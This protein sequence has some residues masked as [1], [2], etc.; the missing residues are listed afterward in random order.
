[1][2]SKLLGGAAALALTA[3]TVVAS[4]VPASAQHWRHWHHGWHNGW[5][6]PAAAA[7]GIVGGAV[8]AATSPLWAPGYYDYYP[9]YAY[10]GY[11]Y[12]DYAYNP[13]YAQYSYNDNGGYRN[14]YD[15]YDN[16]NNPFKN[17]GQ[18]NYTYG[19]APGTATVVAQNGDNV[20][21][22]QSRYRSYDPA[23]GTFLGFDGKRH[24]CP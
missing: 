1:M 15:S 9:N 4:S 16:S 20:A 24:P 12:P 2:K 6:W 7:A 8:A 23:S 22:C 10:S 14:Y 19:P 11:S 13:G 21:Y 17:T 18:S 5:G 3:C